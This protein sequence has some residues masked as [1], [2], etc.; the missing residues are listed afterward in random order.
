LKLRFFAYQSIFGFYSGDC[1]SGSLND[2]IEALW[3][4]NSDFA[5]DFSVQLNVGFFAAVDELA[6]S[7]APLPAGCAQ[8]YNPQTSEIPFSAFTVDPSIDGCPHDCF[9]GLVI[10]PT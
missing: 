5:Q 8:A 3:V 7:Y 1:S 2:S 4:G 10:Q 6:V 9:F